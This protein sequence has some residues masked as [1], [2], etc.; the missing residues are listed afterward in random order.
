MDELT[1]KSSS[2]PSNSST[3]DT[4]TNDSTSDSKSELTL[5]KYNKIKE[6]MSLKEVVDIFG[7]EGVE[8]M[9]SG[10]GKYKVTSY[11]WEGDNY[12]FVTVI[13]TNDKETS[14]VQYGLK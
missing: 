10:S 7:S 8:Q 9:S 14:K 12:A 6:G 4:T 1:K 2:T 13:F 11:K 3:S 5:A